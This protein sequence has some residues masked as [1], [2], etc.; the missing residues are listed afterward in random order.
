MIA[1]SSGHASSAVSSAK[2]A[3]FHSCS[4]D[5]SRDGADGCMTKRLPVFGVGMFRAN[6]KRKGPKVFTSLQQSH[7]QGAF[8]SCSR[9]FS[10]DGADGCMTKRFPVF[11]VGMF[12]AN[13]KRKSPK[14]FTS[15][16]QSHRQ[17][18]F[19]IP[20]HEISREMVKMDMH[21]EAVSSIWRGEV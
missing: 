3:V 8:H 10:R 17:G 13:H 4:R 7:R 6:H 14:V 12:G 11:G 9:D 21:D 15:L 20:V 2:G 19:F 16:Q 1:T 5:L 18:T